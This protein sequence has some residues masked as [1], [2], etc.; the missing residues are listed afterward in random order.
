MEATAADTGLSKWIDP[1]MTP[2]P[3]IDKLIFESAKSASSGVDH[4][5]SALGAKRKLIFV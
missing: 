1:Q 3:Q 2:I 4:S 5:V